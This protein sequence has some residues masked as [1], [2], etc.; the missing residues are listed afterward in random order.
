MAKPDEI[1]QACSDYQIAFRRVLRA[2]EA[3]QK[4]T[5]DATRLADA[6]TKAEAERNL[7]RAAL[8][9]AESA[10]NLLMRGP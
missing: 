4:A 3:H 7:A 5:L 9:N 2:E 8:A 1:L 10:L 6:V